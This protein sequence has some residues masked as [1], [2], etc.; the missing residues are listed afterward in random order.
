MKWIGTTMSV[1]TSIIRPARSA[2]HLNRPAPKAANSRVA[3][4]ASEHLP[5]GDQSK[6]PNSRWAPTVE[7]TTIKS[8]ARQR[9]SSCECSLRNS[10]AKLDHEKGG[11]GGDF[12]AAG[13]GAPDQVRRSAGPPAPASCR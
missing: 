6:S 12:D 2:P 13:L 3:T 11:G 4:I 8:T 5:T 10:P 9:S 1:A 7:L